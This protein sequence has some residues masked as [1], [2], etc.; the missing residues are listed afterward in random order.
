VGG[1]NTKE[2]EDLT[3]RIRKI[4]WRVECAEIGATQA[5]KLMQEVS[6]DVDNVKLSQDARATILEK[7]TELDKEIGKLAEFEESEKAE[8]DAREKLAEDGKQQLDESR[9]RADLVPLYSREFGSGA[10]EAL[11]KA[12]KSGGGYRHPKKN[13]DLESI[14]S[15]V[16]IE[17]CRN[18]GYNT[19]STSNGLVI[20]IRDQSRIV[21]ESAYQA[22]YN[23]EDPG[24][25]AAMGVLAREIAFTLS[26]DS[27]GR[28]EK[29]EHQARGMAYM[30]MRDTPENAAYLKQESKTDP[31]ALLEEAERS[32][33][34]IQAALS[35]AT[36]E[37][38]KILEKRREQLKVKI[39]TLRKELDE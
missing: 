9:K 18:G 38:Q 28:S 11:L 31:R 27:G 37:R 17:A 1:G 10:V 21:T 14:K 6:S 3:A 13:L 16:H 7:L 34:N 15:A 29:P 5:R 33:S 26:S 39:A 4:R 8:K 20:R 2:E 36:G 22:G 19:S 12:G 24:V 30:E 32:L 23:V 25:Q 35:T